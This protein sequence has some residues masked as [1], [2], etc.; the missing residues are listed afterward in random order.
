LKEQDQA[1]NQVNK[2]WR[3]RT[4]KLLVIIQKNITHQVQKN[5]RR[6]TNVS[7]ISASMINYMENAQ[8]EQN[9]TIQTA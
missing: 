4:P 3:T 8:K 1:V 5:K 2:K 9:F 6:E 7:A